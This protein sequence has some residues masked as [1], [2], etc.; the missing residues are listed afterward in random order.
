MNATIQKSKLLIVEGRDEEMLF[1][2]ALADYL[3]LND[4]QILPIGG[5][6]LLTPNLA[7]LV[8]DPRFSSVQ[9]LAVLRDADS[10]LGDTPAA[11]AGI[12]EAEKAL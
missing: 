3:G 2:A 1:K 11:V 4:I 7:G 9:S 6:T 10:P 8:N 5:K 12:T